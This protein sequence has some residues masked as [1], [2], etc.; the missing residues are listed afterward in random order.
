MNNITSWLV[1]IAIVVGVVV[2]VEHYF[3]SP[4]YKGPCHVDMIEHMERS[5]TS[6]EMCIE[7]ENCEITEGKINF[8]LRNLED[9]EA[10]NIE[11]E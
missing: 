4:E 10:C 7:M 6:H 11:E 1:A 5:V 9:L 3:P 8:Y 2:T